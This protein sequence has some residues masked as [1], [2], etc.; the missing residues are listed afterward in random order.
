MAGKLLILL[1]ALALVY[2]AN[3]FCVE[4]NQKL[5]LK[6]LNTDFSEQY[7]SNVPV[8]GRVI[9][10]LAIIGS[11]TSDL[12]IYI[13]NQNIEETICMRVMSRDGTYISSNQ[14]QSPGSASSGFISAE[15]PTE[16]FKVL[17]KLDKDDLAVLSYPGQCEG[18]LVNQLY[19]SARG[20]TTGKEEVTIF[21]SSGR[22][23][24]F[25]RLPSINAETE[26][27]RCQ[28]IQDGKRTGFDTLCYVGLSKLLQGTNELSLMRR[29]SGRM[30]PSVKFSIL[31]STQ[32]IEESQ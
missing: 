8:S 29:K 31:F 12:S 21:V 20:E 16:Y 7:S 25:L 15:Y 14:Y 19:L 18:S 32:T 22:S 6:L 4:P 11:H 24:V 23:D 9:A 28:R 26:T 30:L 17:A 5:N 10:G 27:I 2:S 3:A 13:P 1:N